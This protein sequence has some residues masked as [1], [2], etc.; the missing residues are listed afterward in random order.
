VFL[1]A[2]LWGEPVGCGGLKLPSQ[3]PAEIKR[4]WVAESARGLGIGRRLLTALEDEA[5]ASGKRRIRLDTNKNLRE[6]I[7]MYR[8]AGYDEVAPFND[9]AYADHWFEK[10]LGRAQKS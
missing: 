8:A 5:R 3:Q 6:A 7:S 9:E 4:M 10:R 1:V 2:T